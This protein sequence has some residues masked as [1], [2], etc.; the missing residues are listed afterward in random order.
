[1][2]STSNRVFFIGGTGNVGS[3]A[4]QDLLKNQVPVTLYTRH[5]NKVADLFPNHMNS[6]LLT[7]VQGDL[8]DLTSLKEALPGHTRLFL[9]VTDLVNLA[10]TKET[11]A[12]IAYEEAGVQQIIDISSI[13]VSYP[14]RVTD[15]GYKH[16]LGEKKILDLVE[17]YPEKKRS[18][19]ALR[20]GR[21]TSNNLTFDRP[22]ENGLIVD[23]VP[24]DKEQGWISPNDIGAIAAVILQDDISKHGNAVYELIGDTV[25]PKRRAELFTEILDNGHTYTY[26]QITPLAKYQQSVSVLTFF[27][28][29]VIF[30]LCTY[31]EINPYV[32]PG[33][34]IL[35]GRDPETL[36]QYIR[37]NKNAFVK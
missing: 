7:I 37:D 27:P 4:V 26:Q 18:F 34:S 23:T 36:E 14:W 17:Q 35:L 30:D 10:N 28:F 32:T 8:S 20:P 25:T 15:I 21:F 33:I 19:V 13:S 1:M 2:V 11:I 6:D 31:K 29:N 24:F 5:P 12:K 3:K 22:T 9:L 16:Y